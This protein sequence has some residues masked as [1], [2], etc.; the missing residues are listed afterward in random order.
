M[1]AEQKVKW[2][3]LKN[4]MPEIVYPCDDVDELWGNA[5][6]RLED[7]LN[8]AE[9]EVRSSGV[10]TGLCSEYSRHYDS[11]AVAAML[12][13]GSWVGWTYWSGGGKHGNPEEIDWIDEAY[14]VVCKETFKMCPVLDFSVEKAV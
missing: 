5:K 12:P 2:L 8:D 9:M 7:D 4:I 3:I 14:D 6:D 1:T 13:D 11:E 10:R